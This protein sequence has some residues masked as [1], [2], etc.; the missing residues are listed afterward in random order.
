MFNKISK[1]E[2]LVNYA[3]LFFAIFP[4]I[5]NSIKGLPVILLF[6]VVLFSD[7]KKHL[8]WKWLL[9]NSSLFLTYLISLSYT[10][11]L[12]IALKKL[13]TGLSMLII[14]IIF[15]GLL[16]QH[17]FENTLK[18][19]FL[20][21]FI[22]S[23]FFFSVYSLFFIITDTT[24]NY[25][26]N[27]YTDKFRVIVSEMPFIGQHPIYASIFLSISIIFF[28]D[29]IRNKSVKSKFRYLYSFFILVNVLLLL[30][31]M[32]KGVILGLFLVVF[33]DL[34]INFRNS[35]I[36]LVTLVCIAISL[37]FFNRRVKEVFKSQM[38]SEINEN[39]S[40]SIRFGIYKC[41]VEVIGE[42]FLLGYGIGDSQRALNLCYS[43][44]SNVLLKNRYNS[45]N[46]YLDILI[47]TGFFGFFIFICFLYLNF[48]EAYKKENKLIL[49]ILIFYC[50][51][52]FTENIL[53][54]QSG[55][56]LFFFLLS[57]LSSIDKTNLP[58]IKINKALQES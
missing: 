29:L 43:N 19:K 26:G 13:E 38:Y 6:L 37:L 54:R 25:Y 46:Q 16:A 10:E 21:F 11:N 41:A 48:R 27:W 18:T 30:L 31:L 42:E 15:F 28:I 58:Q 53:I 7:I 35:K 47:K 45:H 24:T 57:F 32:G 49:N 39:F 22:F 33:I 12:S 20:K 3:L 51:L 40:T 34:L 23:S 36:I 8:N 9:I 1:R 44:Y 52:F 55:V 56:I 5:P 4:L 14:P 50:V 17:S 2:N